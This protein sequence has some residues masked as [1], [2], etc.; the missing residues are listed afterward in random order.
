MFGFIERDFRHGMMATEHRDLT[1][2]QH[3]RAK[4]FILDNY[5]GSLSY[6]LRHIDGVS[7]MPFLQGETL[8]CHGESDGW[9]FVEFWGERKPARIEAI[10]KWI[11]ALND[12]T[13]VKVD[14]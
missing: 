1:P 10:K 2:D 9:I 14:A 5:T 6:R 7:F 11:D 12:A 4:G 8:P 13:F 3:M